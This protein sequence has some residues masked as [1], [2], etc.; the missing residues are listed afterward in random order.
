MAETI[1]N[2]H[3]MKLPV[4]TDLFAA[5]FMFWALPL[6]SWVAINVV[7]AALANY[8]LNSNI[9]YWI[10]ICIAAVV[11]ILANTGARATARD[12]FESAKGARLWL[13][14]QMLALPYSASILMLM[15]GVWMLI[16]YSIAVVF[17]KPH[18]DDAFPSWSC[19]YIPVGLV[20]FAN[21]VYS[22]KKFVIVHCRVRCRELAWRGLYRYIES[23]NDRAE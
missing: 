23:L 15:I 19:F 20:V 2:R 21:T 1:A 13:T 3:W 5:S 6:L 4:Y 17:D 14:T 22:M 7:N 12:M 9:L 8:E 16:W 18:F 10:L 11:W